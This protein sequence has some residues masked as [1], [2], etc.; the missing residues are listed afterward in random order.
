MLKYI[1]IDAHSL[2]TDTNLVLI[3]SVIVLWLYQLME[4]GGGGML[5]WECYCVCGTVELVS[6]VNKVDR[7]TG[8]TK[9]TFNTPLRFSL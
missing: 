5:G 4:A 2:L 6:S 3:R 7:D 1:I 8:N 9:M